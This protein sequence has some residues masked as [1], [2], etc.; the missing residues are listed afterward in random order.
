MRRT[1]RL[2]LRER[3]SIESVFSNL[4]ISEILIFVHMLLEKFS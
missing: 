2:A 1:K 4:E 3:K